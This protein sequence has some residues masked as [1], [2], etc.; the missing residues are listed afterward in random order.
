M[1]FTGRRGS[2]QGRNLGDVGKQQVKDF[3]AGGGGYVGVCAGAYMALQGED[4]FHKLRMSRGATLTGDFWQRGIALA[5]DV[6]APGREP[7]NLFF[8]NGPFFT[9]S[10]SRGWRPTGRWPRS[11]GEGRANM[12]KGTG[13]ERCRARRRSLRRSSA[14][15]ACCC[16]RPTRSSADAGSC[17]K[18]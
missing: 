2:T 8:A 15:G 10:P 17:R 7:F 16:S 9:P 6:S 18:T 5:L 3:V 14:R 12:S 13:P 1:V 4:Q 11:S